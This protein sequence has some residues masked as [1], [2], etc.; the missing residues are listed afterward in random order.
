[1]GIQYLLDEQGRRTAVLIPI[2]D[3]N[4]LVKESE[5]FRSFEKDI[6]NQKKPSDYRGAISKNTAEQLLKY[7]EQTRWR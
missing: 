3:W 4:K 6:Y 1:M 7:V 2:E 5:S